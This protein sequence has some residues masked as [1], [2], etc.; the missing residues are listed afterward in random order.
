MGLANQ[1]VFVNTMQV[2]NYKA[3][4]YD[5]NGTVNMADYTVWR[6]TLGS[7]TNAAADGNG[8]GKVDAADYVLW[9]KTLGQ[10]GGPG[11]G[12]GA[13]LDSFGVPEPSSGLLLMLSGA[14]LSFYR[15]RFSPRRPHQT[16]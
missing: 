4:D 14:M 10:S 12:S 11:A 7:T 13:G 16:R 5:F 6:N 1:L 8:N 3:G 15:P 2:L 9:R